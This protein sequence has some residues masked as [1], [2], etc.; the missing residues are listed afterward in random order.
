MK[1]LPD[2]LERI[3]LES[4]TVAEL[5]LRAGV[6]R[7]TATLWAQRGNAPMPH[8]V[9]ERLVA[10]ADGITPPPPE[11]VQAMC[12]RRARRMTV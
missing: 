1:A 5:A 6:P 9:A 2:Q 4:W 3:A 12:A 10:Q 8:D 11:A 7:S